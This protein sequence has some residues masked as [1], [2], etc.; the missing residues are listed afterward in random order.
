MKKCFSLASIIFVLGCKSPKESLTI[1]DTPTGSITIEKAN[2]QLN[3]G[4]KIIGSWTWQKTICCSRLPKTI[5]SDTLDF[6]NILKFSPN[7]HLEYFN[8]NSLDKMA[9]YEISIGLMDDQ[10]PIIK[11]NDGIPGFIYIK[12]DTLLIIDYGYIDL[13]TEF[14]IK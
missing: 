13:Q 3:I 7:G 10:R 14:Y 12:G 6:P 1:A 2:E 11:I 8:G 5:T 9:T 4:E